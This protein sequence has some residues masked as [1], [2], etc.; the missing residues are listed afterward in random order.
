[1]NNIPFTKQLAAG[2]FRDLT[3]I[4]S[5]NPIMWRDITVQNRKELSNQLKMWTN[6]MIR[7]QDLLSHADAEI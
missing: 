2:G 1:M 5:A 3:R 4:A 6:E 7:L